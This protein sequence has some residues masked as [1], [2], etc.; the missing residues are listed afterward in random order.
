MT[1]YS[2]TDRELEAV[3]LTWLNERRPGP[4]NVDDAVGLAA[5]LVQRAAA[6]L[7]ELSGS[8]L[9][10]PR[11]GRA[12]TSEFIVDLAYGAHYEACKDCQ[13]LKEAK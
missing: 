1:I 6:I 10:D 13:H 9:A 5:T 11:A 2:E 7:L 4:R 8:A 3:V 12:T